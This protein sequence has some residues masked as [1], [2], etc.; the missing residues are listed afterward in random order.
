MPIVIPKNLPAYKKLT[1]ENIFVMPKLRASSQDIRP[2]EIAILN[3]MPTKID[4][5]NQLLRLLSNSPL[6]I[7]LT[8]VK[9]KS[10]KSTHTSDDHMRTFYKTFDQIH[11]LKFD[12]MIITGAPVENM[13]FEEVKYWKELTTIF[14]YCEKNVTSTMFICWA[15]QAACYHYYGTDKHLLDKKLFGVFPNY[16]VE[17]NDMLLKGMN[18]VFYMPQ[19]RH[20]AI[21]EKEILEND[22]LVVL[23]KS[24]ESG[25]SIFKSKD[26]GKIFV[27]GHAEYDRFTLKNEYI[28]DLN[29]KLPIEMP[30]N[31]FVNGDLDKVDMCWVSTANLLFYNW[32]NYYIYQET[33]Y[34]R[35]DINKH[36]NI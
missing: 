12:G 18:D 32:L 31:Y 26:N 5:E 22:E 1:N 24:D 29:K 25:I 10:Y 8:L 27:T 11:D 17:K 35:E 21:D 4:T 20:T 7:N 19:S 36:K 15:S 3:L 16:A 34:V 9:T 2:I 33:P 14:D 6:Q 13:P 23:A 28:R 30:K